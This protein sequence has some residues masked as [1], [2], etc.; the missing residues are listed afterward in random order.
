V[1]YFSFC[2]T[3][4]KKT[5]MK[6]HLPLTYLR[7]VVAIAVS[8]LL[9]SSFTVYGQACQFQQGQNGGV[10]LPVES[11]VQ[12]ERGNSNGSKSHFAEGYSVPYRIEFTTLEANQQYRVRIAFDVKKNEKVSFDYITGFQNLQLRQSL[13]SELVDPLVG[14]GL[15]SL[16]GISS[17]FLAIPAPTFTTNTSF[18]STASASFSQLKTAAGLNPETSMPTSPY[19]ASLRNK[20]NMVIWNAT[21]NSIQYVGG[22]DISPATVSVAMDVVFTK[23]NNANNVVLAWGGHIAS[24]LDWGVGNSASSIPGSPYHMYVETVVKT[25]DGD[26][27]CNGNMDCQIAADAV[28]PVPTCNITGP[29]EL[30]SSTTL[31]NYKAVLDASQNG[32]VS[33]NWSVVDLSSSSTAQLSG[34]VAGVSSIDTLLQAIIPS[35]SFL[36]RLR[37]QRGGIFNYCYLNSVDSPGTKVKKLNVEVQA[38][39]M[40]T[41]ISLNSA[42]TSQLNATIQLNGSIVTTG[43]NYQWTIV[44]PGG[45][46]SGSLDSYSIPDP[47]FTASMAGD[48]TLKVIASQQAAPN[49]VDSATIVISVGSSQGCPS[50]LTQSLCN[51]SQLS[52]P[53]SSLPQPDVD[54]S[55]SVTNG[56]SILNEG[57][58]SLLTVLAGAQDFDITLQLSYANPLLN[59]L[60]CTYPVIVHPL[61]IV[62]AGSYGP[63]CVTASPLSLSGLPAGGTWSGSGVSGSMFTPSVAGAGTIRV[64]YSYTDENGCSSVDSTEIVVNEIPRLDPGTYGPLCVSASPV[65]LQGTPAGGTWSGTGVSGSTFDPS[66]AGVGTHAVNY[67]VTITGG[68]VTDTTIDIRVNPLPVLTLGSYGPTCVTASPLSLSGLPAGGTW[69]GSGVSGS[70]FTPS[71]AGA[72]TIR[73]YYS[74]TD[75]NGCSSVDSTDIVVNE[76]PRL[77]PGTYGPLCVSASPVF[78]QGTPAGGTWSGTGV[79]GSTFDPSVAGVGTHAVNYSVTITGGCVTDTTIDIEVK[80][81]PNLDLGTYEPLCEEDEIITLT[82]TPTG[83]TWSGT[84]T[85]GSTFNPALAGLGVHVLTYHYTDAFGCSAVQEVSIQVNR[86]AGINACTLT[87]GYYGSSNGKSCDED[88]L[89]R[90]AVSIIKKLLTPSPIVIGS[91]ARTLTITV[92]DSARLNAVMPG[93]G[94]PFSFSH[95]GNITL[96]S[97]QFSLYK[98]SRGKINNI[99]LSQTIALALNV[100][101]KPDLAPFVLENGYIHTQRLRTC[102]NADLPSLVT[103][104]EDSMAIRAW[105]MIPSVVNYLLANSGGTVADLLALANEVLGRTKVPGQAGAGGTVVPSLANI[106]AQVD[107]INNAFDQCR[108]FLGFFPTLNLCTSSS[109]RAAQQEEAQVSVV[110]KTLEVKVFPN[111]FG[112]TLNFN[113]Q[114]PE[115]TKVTIELFD[116]QGK[117]LTQEYIGEFQSQEN[118]IIQMKAPVV[119]APILYRV[120]TSKKVFSGVLLP[121]R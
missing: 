76:I 24:L 89:Y 13:P 99:L 48:Y 1:S 4:I 80:P 47:V 100:R 25:S 104:E 14:T 16:S 102:Q 6:L 119:S 56:A 57:G 82:A 12:F 44:G 43:F 110:I 77:D 118:R 31:V 30:C 64:Y 120:T 116:L 98:T 39:A 22:V 75:E 117:L 91:G 52:F 46:A 21:L 66:V 109:L 28:T 34:S 54:Y 19:S 79:S 62:T 59:N 15:A 37:V 87:Q 106:V 61:P 3:L 84:G 51:A 92:A 69:S 88:S 26:V 11:P 7:I 50:L 101:I 42:S 103:C 58:D 108:I 95:T 5:I 23:A 105:L 72:G 113:I 94:T 96:Q 67:S 8:F 78:L 40:P 111:P 32:P 41:V 112:T 2:F 83:G 81:L 68:C 20:G 90:N 45:F 18:N 10:G 70:T 93:G 114:T 74:Y 121:S 55:W 36:V 38:Q 17:S 85:N 33:Y 29:S 9:S 63:T 49:C 65:F 35:D 73:I 71:V 115:K 86:C 27:I 107:I 53:V 60:V 97:S